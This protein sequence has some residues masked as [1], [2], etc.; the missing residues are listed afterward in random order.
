MNIN[1]T[2]GSFRQIYRMGL[3]TATIVFV[4][5]VLGTCLIQCF[6]LNAPGLYR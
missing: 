6:Y 1:K 3:R 5:W 2:F 4:L